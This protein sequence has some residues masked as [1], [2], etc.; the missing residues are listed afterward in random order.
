M[1]YRVDRLLLSAGTKILLVHKIRI[2]TAAIP[3]Q[4]K[5]GNTPKIIYIPNSILK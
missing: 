1:W 2:S 3:R 4:R 5:S